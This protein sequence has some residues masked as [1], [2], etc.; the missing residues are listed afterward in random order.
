LIVSLLMYETYV[1]KN[2]L[3]KFLRK[4]MFFLNLKNT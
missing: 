1:V 2:Q 3:E 4:K